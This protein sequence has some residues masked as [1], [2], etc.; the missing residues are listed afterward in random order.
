MLSVMEWKKLLSIYR[1]EIAI[2]VLALFVRFALIGVAQ[3]HQ[4]NFVAL[5]ADGGDYVNEAQNLIAGH[6]FSRATTTPYIPDAIRTPLYPL[7]LAGVKAVFGSFTAA[8]FVQAFLSSCIPVVGMLFARLFLRSRK[9]IVCIGV[10]L[11]LEP[12]TAFYTTFFS[13]EGLSILLLSVG[14]FLF[15]KGSVKERPSLLFWGG[16]L[17]GLSTLVRPILYLYPIL[18]VLLLV[19][20][21]ISKQKIGTYIKFSVIF[22]AAFILILSPWLIRNYTQFGTAGFGTVGWF[23]VYTR[24]AA[25][26]VAIDEKKDFYI[27]YHE[28]LDRLGEKGYLSHG[29]P[30]S[31]YEIQNPSFAPILKKESIEI[32]KA[33]PKALVSFALTAPISVVTQDNTLGLLDA[34]AGIKAQRPPFSPTLYISQHGVL[35]GT[36]ALLPYAAG[37]YSLAFIARGLWTLLALLSLLGAWR[38]YRDRRYFDLLFLVSFI[39]YIVVFTIN[40]GAQIDGGRYRIQ[41]LIP[42]L[43]LAGVYLE[44]F[45]LRF[46]KYAYRRH[47][48]HL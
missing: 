28:L 22:C 42:E 44:W 48:P 37:L 6:G 24:L 19:G 38:L 47:H 29:P 1:I 10:F 5:G 35:E 7:F 40:A 9:L 41:F 14:L 26:V 21:G 36:K 46:K 8:V 27:S 23:N 18:G 13:S 11:A 31:E 30:V 32:L 12:H 20:L 45:V 4:I 2:F 34:L 3:F 15:Y 39:L 16:A 25:T 17:L 43:I 33:H